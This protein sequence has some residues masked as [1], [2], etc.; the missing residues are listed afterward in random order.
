MDVQGM[1]Q[2]QFL[3]RLGDDRNELALN[4]DTT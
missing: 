1:R 3:C 4:R 2:A